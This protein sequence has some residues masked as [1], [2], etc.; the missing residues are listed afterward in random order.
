[1]VDIK[2]ANAYTEVIEILKYIKQEDYNK[3]P[4]EKIELFKINANNEYSFKYIPTKTLDEQS[5]SNIAKG[6]IAMLFRDYWATEAQRE[7]I[8]AKQSYDRQ[9]IEEEKRVKY[10]SDNLFKNINNERNSEDI[11][12]AI[13]PNNKWYKKVI[14]FFKNIFKA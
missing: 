1:M 3:I 11:S 14:S 8:I 12:L 13:I 5:V 10:N 7:K 4:K 6:I 9:K 2:Y